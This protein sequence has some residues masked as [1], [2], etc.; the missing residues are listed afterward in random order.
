[1]TIRWFETLLDI[2]TER[3]RSIDKLKGILRD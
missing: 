2:D 1:M 3:S